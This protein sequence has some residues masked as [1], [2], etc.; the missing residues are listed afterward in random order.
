MV[1]HL[2]VRIGELYSLRLN[3]DDEAIL[4]EFV[5]EMRDGRLMFKR[6]GTDREIYVEV[7]AFEKM[8]SSGAAKRIRLDAEQRIIPE[9][10]I[11]PRT[12]L[13]PDDPNITVKERRARLQQQ[14]RL[15][16][17]RTL[18]FYV[19][20]YDKEPEVGRGRLGLEKFIKKHLPDAIDEGFTWKP[21]PSS[22]LRGI[23]SCGTPGVRHLSH[24]FK[25]PDRLDRDR[26]WPRDVM[27]AASRAIEA[28]WD[29]QAFTIGDALAM[30][31]AEADAIDAD[32]AL[33]LDEGQAPQ[34]VEDD[35]EVRR[36]ANG[37]LKRKK[38][39]RKSNHPIPCAETIRLWIHQNADWWHWAQRYGVNNANRRFRGRGKA[40]EATRPLE[41]VMF[42]H[43]QLDV[44]AVMHDEDGEPAFVV[45][46][47]LTLAIDCYSRM[48]LGAVLGFDPPSVS[49]VA[50]CLKQVV[51]RKDFLQE[52]YG[53]EKGGAD[54]WGRPFTI[55]VDNGKEF[56]SP[57]FQAFCEA[58]GIDVEWAPVKMPT[59]KAYVERV[60]GTLNTILWHKLPGGLPLTPQ[61]RNALELDPEAKAVFPRHVLE[62][63]MWEA[64]VNLYHLKVHT[65]QGMDIAPALKWRRGIERHKRATV[66]SVEAL[67][68]IFGKGKTAQ[69]SAEGVFVWGHRFHDAEIT[70]SLMNRFGRFAKERQQ[71]HSKTAS[72]TVQVR[73]TWDPTDVSKVHVW[74]PTTKTSVTLPNVS[75]T[76]SDGLSWYG[77]DLIK[78]FA[79]QRNMD[80]HSDAEMA[81]AREAHRKF[82]NDLLPGM[83]APAKRSLARISD[84]GPELMPGDKVDAVSREPGQY[85]VQYDIAAQRAP[86]EIPMKKGRGF[87][88][89]AGQKKA[90][91]T[92]ERNRQK[93]LEA[94]ATSA[95]SPRS[96]VLP[97]TGSGRVVADADA[98]KARV[99][100]RL[101]AQKEKKEDRS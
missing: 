8:R 100:A 15:V 89:K 74:D 92:R 61:D 25:Q 101:K 69:L 85:D 51:R 66:D 23:D 54:G 33:P 68:K 91:A 40:I 75:K 49:T 34:P 17:A 67:D 10:E 31:E 52:I 79:K 16:N 55:I 26:R 64:I 41:Y 82:L 42:D 37:R 48:V 76:Y 88:G 45:R 81:K 36:D 32:H 60:F 71:R 5:K 24:F 99:Q 50:R 21:S 19:M 73:V 30:F 98:I 87:G 38:K 84:P 95:E 6:E 65:G 94:E 97:G 62:R 90:A 1:T 59:Y 46:P 47:Y 53:Y 35:K 57:S 43:T 63:A 80:F 86:D 20:R 29:D 7:D 39:V 12:L 70:S 93:K 14:E 96:P 9:H 28:Y 78:A 3:D 72:R 77:A 11:D 4:A 58:V 2:D 18:R 44:W 83:K 22:L 56:V 13:D 27:Q